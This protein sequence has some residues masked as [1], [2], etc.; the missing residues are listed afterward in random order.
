VQADLHA[1]R[2]LH[3]LRRLRLSASRLRPFPLEKAHGRRHGLFA[4]TPPPRPSD[5][6]LPSASPRPALP[7][8]RAFPPALVGRTAGADDGS[9]GPPRPLHLQLFQG[10]PF[11]RTKFD[12][13]SGGG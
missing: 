9:S 8:W 4:S 2:L 6:S 5:S 11:V 1:L 13:L 7:P 3:E 10:E 12:P